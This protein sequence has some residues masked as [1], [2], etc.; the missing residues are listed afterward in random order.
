MNTNEEKKPAAAPAEPLLA[1][2]VLETGTRY[3]NVIL[4]QG[5]VVRLPKS[6]AETLAALTPPRVHIDGV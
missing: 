4:G 2:V 1:C 3:G 5:A 6:Q